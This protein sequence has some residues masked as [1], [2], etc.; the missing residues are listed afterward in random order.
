[1][2]RARAIFKYALD[3]IPKTQANDVY[4]RFVTFEK[5]HGDR[6]GI[7]VCFF[8]IPSLPPIPHPRRSCAGSTPRNGIHCPGESA[9]S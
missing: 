8:C 7:E 2:E 1:M 9:L 6:E 5:Q 4:R 3:H